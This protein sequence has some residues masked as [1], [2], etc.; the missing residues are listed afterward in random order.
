MF[1]SRA[2]ATALAAVGAFAAFAPSALAV[3][4][5]AGNIIRLYD[6]PGTTGGGEFWV[7]VQGAGVSGTITATNNDFIT[8]CLEKN[9]SFGS[10]GQ[11]LRVAAVSTGAVNGGVSGG[12]PDPLDPGTAWLFTQFASGTLAG[13][14]HTNGNADSLQRAIWFIE[15]EF[16]AGYTLAQLDALDHQAKLWV[17][18][19]TGAGWTDIGLVRVLNLQKFDN[20]SHAWVAS[21]DQLY[22]APVPE[23][24]TYAML[25]AGLG[26]L[27]VAARRRKRT[28]AA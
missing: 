12:N 7:D 13:Y 5:V 16:G 3:P 22:L 2:L 25:L 4:V 1:A 9:E 24:E 26:L 10:F 20:A 23:P 14:S 15:G 21:Q 27:G 17:D 8:F 28:F 18:D 11:P 19:A 6:G